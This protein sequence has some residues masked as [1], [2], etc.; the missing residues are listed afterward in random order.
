VDKERWT[1]ARVSVRGGNDFRVVAQRRLR[2]RHPLAELNSAAVG[3][4]AVWLAGNTIDRRIL[5]L[6]PQTARVVATVNLPVAPRR[7]AVG[8]GA[9]WVTG[10]ID[11]VVFRIDP[12]DNRVV[13]RIPIGR[14]GS[15]I[16]AGGGSVWV[17]NELDGTITR[18]DPGTNRVTET[19]RVGGSP[20]DLVVAGGN[21]WVARGQE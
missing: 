21:V 19:I 14:G 5:K 6:D 4:D 20:R 18:I 9:V 12:R 10:E 17:A 2:L 11:N 7:V 1:V 8:E 16:A 15:G 3:K 13:A